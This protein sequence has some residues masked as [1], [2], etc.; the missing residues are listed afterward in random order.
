MGTI[1][2]A[3]TT[4]EHHKAFHLCVW[5]M[6]CGTRHRSSSHLGRLSG[7]RVGTWKLQSEYGVWG[8]VARILSFHY[9]QS[10]DKGPL[11]FLTLATSVRGQSGARDSAG[12]TQLLTCTDLTE[13]SRARIPGASGSHPILPAE[14]SK[15]QTYA[16][17][18]KGRHSFD[19]Y[20]PSI[21]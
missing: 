8:R 10:L 20:S 16:L 6:W 15:L 17:F 7:E 4:Q 3:Y 19:R 21:S 18:I 5:G 1:Q 11:C 13:E 2:K 9:C 14:V 12:S